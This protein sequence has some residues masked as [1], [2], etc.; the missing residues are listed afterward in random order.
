MIAFIVRRVTQA[1]IVMFVISF[2]GF[3]IKHSLGDPV[4]EMVG[5]SVSVQEREALREQLGLNDPY[6]V[7]WGRFVKNAAQGDLGQSFFYRKPA[8]EVIL[9]KAPATLELVFCSTLLILLISTP[10]GVYAAYRPNSPLSRFFM[11]FS[12]VGVS[13]PVFLTAILLIYI[14]A[15]ELHWLPSYG[16]G[17]TVT[18]FGFWSTGLLTL[19]GLKHLIL[20]S[21]ALSSIMLP[22]FIRLIRAEMK[23]VL[24]TEYVKFARA[25]GLRERRVLMVHAFKNTLLPVITVGGVQI[26]LMIAYTILTETVFQWQGMGF[27]FIEAVERSDTALLVAYMVFVGALFVVVNTVVDIIYGLVNPMVRVAGRK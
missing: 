22:L 27:M 7:Q 6:L 11:G 21:I 9:D 5:V 3:A 17:E 26:G 14:F 15:V 10:V 18:L 12:V 8:M 24:E 25:K 13:I 16:R 4:R 2:I 19:D 23:E 20:P 1:L